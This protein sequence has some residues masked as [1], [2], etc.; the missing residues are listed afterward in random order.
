MTKQKLHEEV[1]SLCAK[2]KVSEEF[3]SKLSELTEPKTAGAAKVEDYVVFGEDGQPVFILCNTHKVWEPVFDEDG[4]PRFKK[5][6]KSKS[7]YFRDCQEGIKEFRKA[8]KMVEDSKTAIMNDVLDGKIQPEEGKQA[9]AE[10][11]DAK[12]NVPDPSCPFFTERPEPD[13]E[14]AWPEAEVV[15]EDEDEDPLS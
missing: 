5:D 6:E 10:I 4:K 13:T 1:M 11:G 14:V 8:R 9:L 15:E 2:Y 7:G 12:S 3:T